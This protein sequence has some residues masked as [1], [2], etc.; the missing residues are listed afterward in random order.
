MLYELNRSAPVSE[1]LY[2]HYAEAMLYELNS[3]NIPPHHVYHHPCHAHLGLV[4]D[5]QEI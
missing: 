1:L 5:G 3:I 4:W 2:E